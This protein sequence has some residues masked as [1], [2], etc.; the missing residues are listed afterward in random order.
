M[1]KLRAIKVILIICVITIL[2]SFSASYVSVL[3]CLEFRIFSVPFSRESVSDIEA[4]CGTH[5]Q[6]EAF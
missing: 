3:C 1:N 2:V 6:R 4:G 5:M